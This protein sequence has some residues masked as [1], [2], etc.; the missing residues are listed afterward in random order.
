[1]HSAAPRR[2][3]R[4]LRK[5]Q[6]A[7]TVFA[8]AGAGALASRAPLSGQVDGSPT[9]AAAGTAGASVFAP[10]NPVDRYA[11]PALPPILVPPALNPDAPVALQDGAPMV[12][13]LFAIF[14]GIAGMFLGDWWMQRDCEENCEESGFIGLLAGGILG[15]L[16]GWMIGGGEIPEPPPGR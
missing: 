6:G 13:V 3:L 2:L 1:M 8:L 10:G 4:L 9:A 15:T 11:A 14:G 5:V 12:P 16:V 7:V